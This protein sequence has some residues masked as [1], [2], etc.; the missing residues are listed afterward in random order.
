MNLSKYLPNINNLKQISNI[1]NLKQYLFNLDRKYYIYVVFMILLFIYIIYL[2]FEEEKYDIILPQ[3]YIFHTNKY[4]DNNNNDI[5]FIMSNYSDDIPSKVDLRSKCPPV[6]DQGKLGL[7][8]INSACFVY[9]YIC[10]NNNIDFNPSRM[11]C[12]Y[13]ILHL[14]DDLLNKISV[15]NRIYEYN[16]QSSSIIEDINTLLLY[17]TCEENEYP[18]PINEEI[19]YNINIINQIDNMKNNI[20]SEKDLINIS[21]KYKELK[22]KAPSKDMYIN[23]QNHKIIDAYKLYIDINEIKKY[24]NYHGPILFGFKYGKTIDNLL[25]FKKKLETLNLIFKENNLNDSDKNSINEYINI[26]N[27]Y[28]KNSDKYHFGSYYDE[29]NSIKLPLN[30]QKLITEYS[31]KY[32]KQILEKTFKNSNK[33]DLTL[34]FPTELINES[35]KYCKENGIDLDNIK[36]NILFLQENNI[37]GNY[38]DN[39]DKFIL[40][41]LDKINHGKQGKDIYN[42]IK[43]FSDSTWHTL[44]IVG[45]DDNEKIFTIANSW[46]DYWGDNGYFYLDYEYFNNKD[47]I[48]GNNIHQLYCLHNTTDGSI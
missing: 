15:N 46:G 20:Y 39:Y 8:H 3:Q 24:L 5:F 10:L 9:R 45:Y 44:V 23:A 31:N 30:I 11:F 25:L 40:N 1:N 2:F 4:Y 26:L 29:L 42:F 17:G 22:I 21:E 7:C 12:E 38:L 33:K 6:Y 41:K 13:N 19:E 16:L 43:G 36:N 37:P 27:K 34:K 28:I 14:R 47:P 48:W 35:E 18:Y 32:H